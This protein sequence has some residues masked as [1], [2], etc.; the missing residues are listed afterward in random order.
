MYNIL[1][2]AHSGLRWLV[3]VFLLAAIVNGLMKWQ[4][5]AEAK[6]MDKTIS[7]LGLMFTHIQIV[8]GLVLYFMS[9]KVN[10]NE[11]WMKDSMSR[12]YGMEHILMMIIAAVVITIGYSKA[13]RQEA[14]K[15]FKTTFIFYLIGLLIILAG[16]PWP[17]RAEL[18]GGWF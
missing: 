14:P 13:K 1:Q 11:G 4:A 5:K 3:L 9:P 12:F 17:F 8:I 2:S 15:K 10:F 7:L 18:G 6:K 16:I